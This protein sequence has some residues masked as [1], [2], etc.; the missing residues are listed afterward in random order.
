MKIGEQP[1]D[2]AAATGRGGPE[3][4]HGDNAAPKTGEALGMKFSTLN[5]DLAKQLG[6]DGGTSGAVVTS[7]AHDSPAAKAGLRSGDVVTQVGND[8]VA[9]AR[10][11][12]DALTKGDLKKG[13]RLSVLTREGSRFVFLQADDDT[14]N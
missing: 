14:S 10:E 4:A 9:N 13:I 2:V 7:I 5:D 6:L 1:E 8:A 12:A 11:A 3:A